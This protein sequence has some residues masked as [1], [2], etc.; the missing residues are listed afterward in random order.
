MFRSYVPAAHR[1][2]CCHPSGHPVGGAMLSCVHSHWFEGCLLPDF[3]SW[4]YHTPEEDHTPGPQGGGRGRGRDPVACLL[5]TSLVRS[6]SARSSCS[7]TLHYRLSGQTPDSAVSHACCSPLLLSPLLTLSGERWCLGPDA[8]CWCCCRHPGQPVGKGSYLP[9]S[10]CCCCSHHCRER[11]MHKL[12]ITW[13]ARRKLVRL[14]LYGWI[15]KGHVCLLHT[16]V[17]AVTPLVTLS[18]ERCLSGVQPLVFS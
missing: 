5:L 4:D 12:V 3:T 7:T 2:C 18:G 13:K 15:R 11:V 17:V 10:H 14:V 16:A 9:V 6:G 8:Y 1:C